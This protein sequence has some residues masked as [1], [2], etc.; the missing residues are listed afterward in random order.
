VQPETRRRPLGRLETLIELLS[1]GPA[2]AI[3]LATARAGDAEPWPGV[4]EHGEAPRHWWTERRAN[5]SPERSMS[6]APRF[7]FS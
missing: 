3:E 1:R 6:V 4:T 5:E 7:P 2:K